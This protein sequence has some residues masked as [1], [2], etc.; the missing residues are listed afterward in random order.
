M[1]LID[2]PPMRRFRQSQRAEIRR[3]EKK[4]EC[5]LLLA[6]GVGENTLF[7]DPDYGAVPVWLGKKPQING[8]HSALGEMIRLAGKT[9]RAG[10]SNL[11]EAALEISANSHPGGF[12][13][14]NLPGILG[15]VANKILLDAFTQAPATYDRVAQQADFS[16][17]QLHTVYRLD[18]LGDFSLVPKDGEIKHGSLSQTSFTNKLDT[19]GQLLTL[20]RQDIINDNLNAFR[21]L[22]EQLGRRAKLALERAL[23]LQICEATDSFYTVAQGNRL[24]GPLGVNELGAAEAALMTMADAWGDPIYAKAK[25][26]LAP[27]ALK[28][29][30]D[31]LYTSAFLSDFTANRPKPTEN[32]FRGRFEVVSSPYLQAATIPGS[33]PTT[34][35]LL[36]DPLALPAFQVAYLRG[37]RA[38]VIEGS[39]AGFNTLGLQMRAVWDYGLAQLDYRG[40]VKSSAT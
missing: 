5:G 20:S 22:P 24:V 3:E 7:A 23:Y 29:L 2:S 35:Y 14:I 40:A 16:N 15:N 6:C 10:G 21:S 33:S 11:F 13:T 34:W 12:S 31:Q 26:L 19:Y 17:F 36:G 28:F 4:I 32:P 18:H 9:P 8:L 1:E 30:A 27:P 39:D 25:Y 37:A 38:P